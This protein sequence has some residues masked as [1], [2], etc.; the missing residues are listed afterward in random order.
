MRGEHVSLIARAAAASGSSPHARG[1]LAIRATV[2]LVSRIIPAC[3][4]N[5]SRPHLRASVSP[6]HPRMRGE[7]I[8][9]QCHPVASFGSSPHARGTLRHW[10][11]TGRLY[12]IIPACAGNTCRSTRCGQS[13]PDHPRMRG[14]HGSAT[15]TIQSN[16]G[17]SPHARGTPACLACQ[18]SNARIIPACAGNTSV[19]IVNS[20]ESPDHPRMRGEHS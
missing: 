2:S 10:L 15:R 14:E 17:S 19:G 11:L 5:T 7:H 8:A 4:G 20:S 16:T 13:R 18:T 12:R 6:D 9:G 3:A 1:T